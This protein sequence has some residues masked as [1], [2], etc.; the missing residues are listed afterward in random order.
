[1]LG[2][3]VN[4]IAAVYFVIGRMVYWPYVLIMVAGALAGGYGGADVARR[5][6]G[7]TV[8][9]IVIAIGFGMA[10]SLFIKK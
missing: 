6:G 9:K 2:G 5:I 10:L 7:A 8:R 1:V 4:G 3:A